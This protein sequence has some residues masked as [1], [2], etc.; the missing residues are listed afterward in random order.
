MLMNVFSPL[1]LFCFL[2]YLGKYSIVSPELKRKIKEIGGTQAEM[3]ESE[4]A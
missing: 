2:E 4:E 3:G 1:C